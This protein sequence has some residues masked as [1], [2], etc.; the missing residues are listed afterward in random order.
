MEI[1]KVGSGKKCNERLGTFR[2]FVTAF[3]Q[4]LTSIQ[5]TGTTQNFLESPDFEPA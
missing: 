1:Y 4:L 2:I 5:F 3:D